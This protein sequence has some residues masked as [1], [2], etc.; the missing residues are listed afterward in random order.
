MVALLDERNASM[1]RRVIDR[2]SLG[3]A[4][5]SPELLLVLIVVAAAL[6]SSAP[7]LDLSL[8]CW[9]ASA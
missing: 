7:A 1:F 2:A 6:A 9:L 8:D 5:C 3:R 4:G